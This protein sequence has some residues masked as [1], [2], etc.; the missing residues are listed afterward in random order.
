MLHNAANLDYAT[1]RR[2]AAGRCITSISVARFVAGLGGY[3]TIA[4]LI[5]WLGSMAGAKLLG[6]VGLG[7]FNEAVLWAVGLGFSCFVVHAQRKWRWTGFTLGV[8]AGVGLT[9]IGFGI[10]LLIWAH[11]MAAF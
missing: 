4:L 5:S 3:S 9:L 7:A 6:R 8:V 11:G 1:P 10:L 2:D